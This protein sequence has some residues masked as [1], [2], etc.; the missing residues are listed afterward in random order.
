MELPNSDFLRS[1]P[2]IELHAFAKAHLHQRTLDS[3]HGELVDCRCAC[4]SGKLA[5]PFFRDR[6]P[7]C[8]SVPALKLGVTG[9]VHAGSSHAPSESDEGFAG[10]GTS[11]CWTL[12][13]ATRA[14]MDW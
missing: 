12:I 2:A 13:P 10:D 8:Y 11:F 3:F 6:H 5:L 14:H 1:G 4:A 7:S 9:F